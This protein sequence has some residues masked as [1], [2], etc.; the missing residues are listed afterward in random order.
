[1]KNYLL[2]LVWLCL[3][4][5]ALAQN[6]YEVAWK[7]M[8]G[9]SYADDKLTKTAPNGWGSGGAASINELAPGVDGWARHS[10]TSTS[11]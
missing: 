8:V 6:V 1:M 3:A 9:V 11:R 2:V 10:H 4:L 7:D 5:P